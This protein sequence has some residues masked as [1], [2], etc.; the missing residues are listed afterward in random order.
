LKEDP[1]PF[2]FNSLITVEI[3]EVSFSIIVGFVIIFILIFLSALISG[4]EVSFFSLNSQKRIP[5]R[6]FRLGI[7]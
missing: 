2:L 7:Y 4:S 5:K 6:K 3:N 1:I